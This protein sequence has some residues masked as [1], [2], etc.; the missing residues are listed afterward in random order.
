[1]SILSWVTDSWHGAKAATVRGGKRERLAAAAAEVFHRQGVERTTLGDIAQVADVPVGNIYYYFKTKDQLVEAAL[2]THLERLRTTTAEL[3]QLPEPAD[4]L[5]ALID[6]WVEQRETAVRFGCPLG[7]LATELD[8][9]DEGLDHAAADVMRALID[10][11]AG[12]F[13]ELGR[14][15]SR[16]LAIDLVAAYQGMSVLTNALR[17]P[18]I[19]TAQ[20]A[21]LSAWIDSFLPNR[22]THAE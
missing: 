1:V 20:G 2:G 10:W 4:R 16:E 13:A 12:Q 3:E 11:V 17:D 7:T 15:D 19:M 14:T 21:R 8:K 9:R 18:E 6:G 5:K 22:P